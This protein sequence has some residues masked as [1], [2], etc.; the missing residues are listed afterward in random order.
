VMYEVVDQAGNRSTCSFTITV[1]DD[2]DPTFTCP[3]DLFIQL[4]QGQCFVN[5]FNQIN[6]FEADNCGDMTMVS[7]PDMDGQFMEGDNVVT[8]VITDGA[9]NEGVCSFMITVAAYMPTNTEMAC[10]GTVN[11]SLDADCEAVITA[12]MILT[13]MDIGCI[14]DIE[15]SISET[16]GGAPIPTSPMVTSE[17]LN[18]TLIVTLF[19]P[20]TG[21]S[22][23]G[24]IL[25]E[26]KLNPVIDC[27]IDMTVSCATD[28]EPASLGAPELMSCEESTTMIFTDEIID[29]GVCG[30]PR[31]VHTRTWIVTD[32]SGN[33]STCEHTITVERLNTGDIT[34]PENYDDIANPSFDCNAV[35]EDPLLIH[36]MNTGQ[37]MIDGQTVVES[38]YCPLSINMEDEAFQICN[39][40]YDILR[41]FRVYDP[42]LPVDKSGPNPNPFHYIQVIKVRDNTVPDVVCPASLVVSVDGN[43]CSADIDFPAIEID[44]ACGTVD[45]QLITPFGSLTTNGGVIPNI[46]IGTFSARYVVTDGCG[47]QTEC[48]I[49]VEVLDAIEPI[50]VCNPDVVVS[51]NSAGIAEVYAEAFDQGTTDNCTLDRLEVRRMTTLCGIDADLEFGMTVTFCCADVGVP[52]MVQL[53]AY[54]K[55]GNFNECMVEVLIDDKEDAEITCPADITIDCGDDFMDLNVTGSATFTDNCTGNLTTADF[56]DD[57]FIDQCGSGFVL[58]TWSVGTVTCVQRID[59]VDPEPFVINDTTCDNDDPND[60]VIWP[61]DVEVESCSVIQ[62]PSMAG[63]PILFDDN[64]TMVA[65]DYDDQIFTFSDNACFKII[66]TWEVIDWCTY[67]GSSGAGRY[68]YD[69]V[70][71]IINSMDPEFTS[72]EA[73]EA[74]TSNN[75][76][77]ATVT[78]TVSGSDD[79]T[80]EIDLNYSYQ[81]DIN[82][83]GSFNLNGS[84]NSVTQ[85][86]AIGTHSILWTI[87]DGCGNVNSCTQLINVNDCKPPTVACIN[88]LSTSLDAGTGSIEIWA[89]DFNASSTDNCTAT[90][91]LIYSFSTDVN[92]T[93]AT[94]TCD[95]LPNGI[96]QEIQVQMWVTDAYGNQSFCTTTIVVQD[97]HDDCIDVMLTEAEIAGRIMTE[98]QIGVNQVEIS[99]ENMDTGV[100]YDEMSDTLGNY[101]FPD[102]MP[103]QF[104]YTIKPEKNIDHK[105]GITALDLIT[106]KKHLLQVDTLDSPYKLIAADINNSQSVTAIDLIQLQKL[107]LGVFD[108]FPNNTSWRFVNQDFEFP[109]A[110]DPWPFEES[111]NI[112]PLMTNQM[113]ED[114]IGVKIGDV[115]GSAHP[116]NV[117][118]KVTER[119][120]VTLYTDDLLLEENKTVEIPLYANEKL[121]INALQFTL[122]A[123]A[124]LIDVLEIKSDVLTLDVNDQASITDQLTTMLWY[125]HKGITHTGK[126]AILTVVLKAKANVL[127]SDALQ[128]NSDVTAAALFTTEEEE[129]NVRLEIVENNS[130][131]AV[132]QNVPNPFKEETAIMITVPQPGPVVIRVYNVLGEQLMEHKEDVEK[133]FMHSLLSDQLGGVAG[134]Y[135]YEVSYQNEVIQKNVILIN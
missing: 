20:T 67:N 3:G 126:E 83:D 93:F 101:T 9:G 7:N 8:I 26:D 64:C 55:V 127:L 77:E 81:L 75:S 104:E 59:L 78:A 130:N 25:I 17:Y 33:S 24:T 41:T 10:Q 82:N 80:A 6:L 46:A 134:M 118:G 107:L 14:D 120:A 96:E 4:G 69:Q 74:C 28:L 102:P 65:M 48:S 62:D 54:D 71:K 31:A 66:R 1:L 37:P 52:V 57:P 34:F 47:N 90:E 43:S 114:F 44:E 45:V 5:V 15:V 35:A 108:E 128:L 21:N 16:H 100:P 19:N 115:N 99:V 125:D 27:P 29:N 133:S 89:V 119:S 53:R 73:V 105:N 61:C 18:E 88:G 79:C 112:D 121:D 56:T 129:Y 85:T 11:I 50:M 49:D 38:S 68:T 84:G 98:T 30:V 13:S 111:R 60:G 36:P 97:V 116:T 72:C 91:D 124:D 131:F 23:W 135:L 110:T 22:C 76:C 117:T 106:I 58:R 132:A 123:D 113:H 94:F 32:E 103:A 70:I 87:T 39:G 12:D 86:L 109:I 95:D 92:N 42:C 122:K 63:E 40:S 51:L 2:E